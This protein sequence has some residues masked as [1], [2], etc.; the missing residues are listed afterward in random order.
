M[1]RHL[2]A[3]RLTLAGIFLLAALAYLLMGRE[4]IPV[5]KVAWKAQIIPSAITV[6]LGVTLVWIAITFIFGRVYCSTV[7]PVGTLQD[8]VIALKRKLHPKGSYRF[9]PGKPTRY[10]ILIIYVV[11]LLAGVIAV[12]L[13]IEPWNIVSNICGAIRP[14]TSEAAWIQLGIGAATGVAGGIFSALLLLIC[15]IFTGRGFCNTV[16]PV[17]TALSIIEPYSLYHIEINPDKCTSCMKCE[18]VCPAQCVK[19]VSRYVDNSRCVR[20]FDCLHACHDDA[21]RM[22][23][24]RNRPATP[25]MRKTVRN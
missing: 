14:S 7:C 21:I 22:Q 3:I 24:N 13:W 23:S 19:V 17:G 9:Q 2:R 1:Q 20:C 4:A 18:E 25:L 15:A 16:C 10:H 5:A 11:C 6:T 12:P 8:I